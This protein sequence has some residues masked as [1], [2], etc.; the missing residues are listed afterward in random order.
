MTVFR[1]T[2]AIRWAGALLAMAM[3]G[4]PARAG[5]VLTFDNLANTASGLAVPNMYGGSSF[6]W[7]NFYYINSA[8]F[9]ANNGSPSG[10]GYGTVSSPNVA[11]NFNGNSATLSSTT[12][13]NLLSGDFTGAWNDNLTF[14]AQAS[15][16]GYVV[17]R[18]LSATSPSLVTFDFYGITSVTFTSSGGTKHP[19]FNGSGTQFVLDN[20][21]VSF[22]VGSAVPEPSTG[23]LAGL[24]CAI[25]GVAG[26]RWR[27]RRRCAG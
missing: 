4:E 14:K 20:L 8:Q 5:N 16:G 3:M 11:Y 17:T 25:A 10:F 19:G 13:F 2:A 26:T 9:N 22:G 23:V 15:T 27:R 1:R 12:P 24:A 7:T 21:T 6:T 18:T